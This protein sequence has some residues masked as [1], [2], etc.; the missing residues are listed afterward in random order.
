MNREGMNQFTCFELVIYISLPRRGIL[1]TFQ[2]LEKSTSLEAIILGE[3]TMNLSY[4][5]RPGKADVQKLLNNFIPLNLLK[6][7]RVCVFG[8]IQ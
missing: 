5:H 2:R 8:T 6:H 1:N 3:N 4:V 7:G